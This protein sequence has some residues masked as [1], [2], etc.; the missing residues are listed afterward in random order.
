MWFHLFLVLILGAHTSSL[1][2]D[3]FGYLK[4]GIFIPIEQYDANELMARIPTITG[5][6]PF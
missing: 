1:Y 2:N 3:E 6:K 4:S 5:G